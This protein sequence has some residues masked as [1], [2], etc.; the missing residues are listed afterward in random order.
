MVVGRGGGRARWLPAAVSG[1][2]VV[3]AYLLWVFGHPYLA[4]GTA[5]LGSV[6][7]INHYLL[8]RHAGGVEPY[9]VFFLPL[10]LALSIYAV[11]RDFFGAVAA[12]YVTVTVLAIASSPP[13]ILESIFGDVLGNDDRALAVLGAAALTSFIYIYVYGPGADPVGFWAMAGPLLEYFLVRRALIG[14]GWEGDPASTVVVHAYSAAASLMFLPAP[15]LGAYSILANS[16]KGVVRG[17]YAVA[18]LLADY[19][20]RAAFLLILNLGRIPVPLSGV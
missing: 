9:W 6:V 14:A 7:S 10:L 19:L 4:L 12:M 1:V 2:G 3:S 20:F 17:K 13:N 18:S 11:L 8:S 16:V 15:C 5:L